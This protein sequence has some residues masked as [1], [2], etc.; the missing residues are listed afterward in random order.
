M[1]FF[2]KVFGK[3]LKLTNTKVFANYATL[4]LKAAGVAN[5]AANRLKATVYLCIAQI[6]CLHFMSK[7]ATAVFVDA[8]VD[9]VQKSILELKMKV[10][11]LAVSDAELKKIL[12]Y[13]P[14][15]AEVDRSTTVY[16]L[17]AFQAIYSQYVEEL[18]TDIASHTGGPLGA[19]GYAAIKILDAIKGKGKGREH[20]IEVSSLLQTMT[21]EVIKAFR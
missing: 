6:A 9:D 11:D 13:F 14:P 1:G 5:T 16:G 12:A 18:V 19:H 4:L 7:G 10:G 20:I 8:M 3:E 17:T 21:G 15:K 2:S